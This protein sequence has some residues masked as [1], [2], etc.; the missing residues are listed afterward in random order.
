MPPAKVDT[1]VQSNLRSRFFC[2]YKPIFQRRY[3]EI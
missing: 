3:F 1:H 2:H